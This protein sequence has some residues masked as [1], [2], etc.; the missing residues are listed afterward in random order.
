MY[1]YIYIYMI[2]IYTH[3]R[4]APCN[5]SVDC[6]CLPVSHVPRPDA[7]QSTGPAGSAGCLCFKV[8]RP[9]KMQMLPSA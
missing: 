3:V 8:P 6:F 2:Y 9:S 4:V 1:I 5:K 7:M